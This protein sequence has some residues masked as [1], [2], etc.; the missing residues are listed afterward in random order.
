MTS[1]YSIGAFAKAG[2]VGVE[3]VRYYE[4][5]RL[6]IQPVRRPGGIRKYSEADLARLRFIKRAQSAGFTLDEVE[7]LIGFRHSQACHDTRQVLSTKLREVEGRLAEL[8]R[9]RDDLKGL[10]ERCDADGSETYCPALD[11]LAGKA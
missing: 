1:S 11:E 4:R 3:T 5:R 7:D 10:I 9:L 2:G 8:R 6:L